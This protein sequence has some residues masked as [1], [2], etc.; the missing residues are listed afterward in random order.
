M[1]LTNLNNVVLKTSRPI[2]YTVLNV[3]LGQSDRKW[4]AL[5]ASVNNHVSRRVRKCWCVQ[6]GP[7]H[8]RK[9]EIHTLSSLMMMI[10]NTWNT[11]IIIK[12][13]ANAGRIPAHVYELLKQLCFLS[14][15]V[16][17][18]PGDSIKIWTS[19]QLD[20]LVS[21]DV[22]SLQSWCDCKQ[23]MS[24]SDLI[25]QGSF[26]KSSVNKDGHKALRPQSSRK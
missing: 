18:K 19:G 7:Q 14:L 24:N 26:L 21:G 4:T 22:S 25:T 17:N 12:Y 1:S 10:W 16:L 8:E 23:V 20:T 5:N 3:C 9:S 6:I 2:L 13:I 15:P 11:C